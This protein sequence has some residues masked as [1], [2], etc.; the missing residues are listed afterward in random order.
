MLLDSNRPWT[1][2]PYGA[3]D[4]WVSMRSSTSD[5]W[6][7]PESLGTFFNSVAVDARPALSFDGTELYFHSNR[8]FVS[9]DLYR[10]TRTKLKG[11]GE[12]G[13]EDYED[14]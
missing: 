13:S 5:P 1:I 9:N 2:G 12:D 10:S 7:T 6:S 3:Q 14:R 4:L 11:I 8:N